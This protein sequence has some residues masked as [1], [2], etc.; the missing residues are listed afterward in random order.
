MKRFIN[1]LKNGSNRGLIAMLV[2]TLVVSGLVLWSVSVLSGFPFYNPAI[3]LMGGTYLVVLW[4]FY[5]LL[6]GLTALITKIA[7]IRLNKGAVWRMAMATTIFV[8]IL[9]LVMGFTGHPFPVIIAGGY[10]MPLVVQFLTCLVLTVACL[11]LMRQKVATV[12]VNTKA[13][14]KVTKKKK[15]A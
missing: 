8:F 7:R 4:L 3:L 13:E 6:V 14:K 1:Y 9:D 5:L 11:V 2:F 10:P 12:V 15:K